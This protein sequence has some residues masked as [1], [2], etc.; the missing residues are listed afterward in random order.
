MTISN[1]ASGSVALQTLRTNF[2][3]QKNY[4]DQLQ[5]S[6]SSGDLS[7]AQ[8]AYNS[9]SNLIQNSAGA[10]NGQPFGGNST[11]QKDFSAL[12]DAL[13]SGDKGNVQKAF[14]QFIQD[15]QS[16]RQAHHHHGAQDADN[17]GDTNESAGSDNDGT[18]VNLTA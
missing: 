2:Q 16:A 12:G 8:Q 15:L 9:L 1:V 5:Q 18:S 4:L 13:K 6:V 14:A 10:K 17:D 7:G 11:L 3:D